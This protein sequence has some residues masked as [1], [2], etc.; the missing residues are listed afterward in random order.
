[1]LVQDIRYAFRSLLK[2]PGF[3]AI[4]VACL[5]LGIGVNATIFSVVDGVILRPFPYPDPDRIV[6]VHSMNQKE[7][8]ERGGISYADFKDFRDSSATI[9]TLAAFT[10]RSLTIA[11]GS[12]DPE[13]YSG[14]TVSWTLFHLLGMQP[15]AGRNFIAQDDLPGAEPVVLLSHD[16][17]ER[18]YQKDPGVI[19]RAITING[20][21]HTV[22]GVMPPRFLFPE[23]QYMW[24]PISRYADALPR[25]DRGTQ[26]FARMKP[27]VTREQAQT[28]LRGLSTRLA[29]SYPIE[30]EDWSVMLRS[31][32]EWMLPAD[33]KLV[34]LTMMGAATLVLLIACSNVANLLLARA[35]VRQREISIRA[36][37]GAGRWRI[38]RQLLTEAVMIG[39][40]AAPLGIAI[41]FIG[42]KL[43]D[44]AMPPGEVPYFIQW[45]VDG[46]SLAYTIAISILTGIVFGLAPALQAVRTNLQS[47]LKE[48]GRGSAGGSRAILRNSL[49]VVEIALSLV[50]L[51]G[52]SLFVRSFLNI[53]SSSIGFDTAKLMTMRFY[54]PGSAYEMDE[55]RARRV[56]DIVRRVESLPGVEAAFSSNLV[57]MGGGGGGGRA[58][59]EGRA[60]ERGKE[61]GISFVAVT[62][63]LRRTLGLELVKGRDF[64]DAEGASRS[65]V[66]MINQEM[67]RKLWPDQDPVGRRFR[68]AGNTREEWFSIIGILADFRHDQGDSSEPEG[69]SAYVPYPYQAS[70]NTGITI[71]VSGDPTSIMPAVREQIRLADP[72]LPVFQVETMERLRELSYWQ[73][74]L[75]SS[76]FSTFGF[77]ALILASIGV[78]GVLSY[79]VSQ[80][81]Q[82][83]GVRL[84]LGAE[85]SHV[86]KLIVGQ[87]VK[88]AGMGVIGG[89]IGAAAVTPVIRTLL[90]NVTPTDPLSFAGVAVFLTLIAMLASYIPARRAMAVDPIVALRND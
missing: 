20:R 40:I 52:A 44:S 61:P 72:L 2:N 17:W 3:T 14:A 29:A 28:D 82:E 47:S 9:Q 78:Y 21:P 39:L 83:I 87:G 89:L 58:I 66:A 60:V 18:R 71:R 49:V 22:I 85:R 46:R 84:A 50:L 6:V 13:R 57:P 90:F 1:M 56:D 35:S 12:G 23:N 51:V 10:Q 62:P 41:A 74:R 65:S 59:I 36:A 81:V 7:G 5:A 45:S 24:V 27:G 33:V 63:H 19:N 34:I 88:L 37:L 43:L 54:L 15:V 77:I 38:V 8:V 26:V 30:N 75:F 48:G 64:T 16:I 11:D 68:L 79:S 4:A 53:Q 73:F 42:I 69:P 86:L 80:R 67:A 31:L 55:A 32:G 25:G 76:M 70:L